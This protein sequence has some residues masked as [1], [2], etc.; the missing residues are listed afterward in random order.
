VLLDGKID[1]GAYFSR[2]RSLSTFSS[3]TSFPENPRLVKFG[4]IAQRPAD[5]APGEGTT[6]LAMALPGILPPS[7]R[8]EIV[9]LTKVYSAYGA[10]DKDGFV[11]S[12]R[13]FREVHPSTSKQALIGG[14]SKIP[15]TGEITLAICL[16]WRGAA[17]ITGRASCTDA[18]GTIGLMVERLTVLPH[19]MP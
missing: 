8:E 15:K 9:Q 19:L 17:K 16:L 7:T 18:T 1:T 10:L 13:H 5:W 6:T 12:R 11:V 4:V 2:P 3:I 14:G